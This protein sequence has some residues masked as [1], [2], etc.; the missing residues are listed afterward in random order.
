MSGYGPC[1]VCQT[2]SRLSK[3]KGLLQVSEGQKRGR[4]PDHVKSW[5][6][7]G[8]L[9]FI[10]RDRE[11]QEDFGQRRD[12]SCLKLRRV[13]L[14]TV[15]GVTTGSQG[16]KEDQLSSYCNNSGRRELWIEPRW[17]QRRWW[18]VIR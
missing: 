3:R 9:A 18:D 16:H 13:T 4:Q 14:A 12:I 8:I 5:R 15:L 1:S 6:P 11:P 17:E 7:L 2:Q 10:C